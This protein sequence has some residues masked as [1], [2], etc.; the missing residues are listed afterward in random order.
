MRAAVAAFALV[1]AACATPT[2]TTTTTTAD[3]SP[4]V[5]VAVTRTPETWRGVTEAEYR[6]WVGRHMS[7]LSRLAAGFDSM[8]VDS[9]VM[10]AAIQE[11]DIVYAVAIMRRSCDRFDQEWQD[12]RR[13]LTFPGD[14]EAYNRPARDLVEAWDSAMLYCRLWTDNPGRLEYLEA[15]TLSM[16]DGVDALTRLK[17][18]LSVEPIPFSR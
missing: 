12:I 2:V 17:A 14:W 4:V 5:T 16:S 11:G 3:M 6:E 7:A 9:E 18:A 10:F 13:D 8:A 15:M 1:A